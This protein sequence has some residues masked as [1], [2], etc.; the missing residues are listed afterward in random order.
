[1]GGEPVQ[2]VVKVR[3]ISDTETLTWTF[4]TDD[5]VDEALHAWPSTSC[6]AAP[7]RL[8]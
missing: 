1:M 6:A 3:V 5:S 2:G 7:A 8:L 4:R